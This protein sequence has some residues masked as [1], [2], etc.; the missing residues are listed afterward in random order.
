MV[1][2]AAARTI[3]HVDM[4]AFYASV[5]VIDDP[6]LT[7]KPV[8]VGGTGPRG[9]V[10]SCTYEARAYG[11]RSAMPGSQARRLCPQA[12][13]VAGRFDRYSEV[14]RQIHAVFEDYTPLVEGI[15]LDEAFL[16]VTGS[17]RL[18]GSAPQIAADIRARIRSQLGLGCSVG[19]AQVKFLAKLASE[20]AKPR[21]SLQG[22]EPGPGVVVIRPREELEFLHPLPIEALWGVGPATAARLRRLGVTTI[23]DLARVPADVL[24]NALGRA[25]GA[26][27]A[28]LARG[29][30]DRPVEPDREIKSVSHEETYPV[31]RYEVEG[32]NVEVVRMADSVASRMRR[33][34]LVGRTVTLK[35]RY[36]D[37]STLTRSRTGQAML[38]EGT[39]IARI[40]KLLLGEV[41]ISPGVRLLGVGVSNLAPTESGSAEQMT[42]DLDSADDHEGAG[43]ESD[44][45]AGRK[46]AAAAVDAIRDR[47]GSAAVG[48]AV[49]LGAGGVRIKRPGD[50][51][52]G[53][54]SQP[55]I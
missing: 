3:L 54:S 2:E 26:H 10:A 48:P 42:L 23:A 32:L 35:I 46:D 33:A 51:Q 11:V 36:A 38:C 24:E 30:D 14:S 7:G 37:F 55:G 16:D 19:V 21:A 50:T 53:P 8:I 6:S 27:L 5:E 39:A 34:G 41:D 28:R 18:F 22:V 4:D 43:R 49:L 45:R 17:L 9:V 25:N 20:A 13:F 40:A 12:V 1:D 44:P 15:S 29:V 31:D 52:W 47:Y